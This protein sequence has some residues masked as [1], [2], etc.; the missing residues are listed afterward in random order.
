[1]VSDPITSCAE[2]STE[3]AKTIQGLGTAIKPISDPLIGILGDQ[4]NYWRA[5]R[6]IQLIEKF[7]KFIGDRASSSVRSVPY[8]FSEKLIKTASVEPDDDLQNI[9]ATMLTNA[10][11]ASF[12]REPRMAYISMLGELSCFDVHILSRLHEAAPAGEFIHLQTSDLPA[13]VTVR[14]QEDGQIKKAQPEVEVSL[15]NLARIG[16]LAPAGAIGGFANFGLVQLTALGVSF[17]SFCS[18]P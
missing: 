3:V 8:N 7:Q 17:I 13:K 2:A 4:F 15:G 16:C 11:D 1:V 6:Q 14:L 12:D 5:K 10:A 18:K 9:W